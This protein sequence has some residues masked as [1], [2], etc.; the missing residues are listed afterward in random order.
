MRDDYLASICVVDDLGPD[1]TLPLLVDLEAVLAQNFRYFEIVYVVTERLGDRF[2]ALVDR[3]ARLPNLRTLITKDNVGFYRQRAIAASEA[4]GDVVAVVDLADLPGN[5]LPARMHQAKDGNVVLLGWHASHRAGG[6]LYRVLS[7]LS[8]NA[9][10]TRA[11]RTIILPRERLNAILTRQHASI[12]LRFEPRGG[13]VRYDHFPVTKRAGSKIR[14][15]HR[16]ELL[17]EIL[18]SGAPRFL[19]IYAALGFSVV[20]AAALYVLYAIIVVLTGSDVQEGWFSTAFVLAGSMG[21]ISM[22]MSILA[23]ALAEVLERSAGGDDRLIVD[24]IANISFFEHLTDR[25]VEIGGAGVE[26]ARAGAR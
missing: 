5:E 16:Y 24:E 25:N 7:L 13:P 26:Q 2:T 9:V 14:T 4:I 11:S 6:L 8:R 22:G 15:A 20:I 3:L 10:S 21:F 23:I 12:D 1:S 18:R 19:K 17:I